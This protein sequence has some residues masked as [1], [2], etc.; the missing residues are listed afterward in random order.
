MRNR[1]FQEGYSL[2]G[3]LSEIDT[4]KSKRVVIGPPIAGLNTR[5]KRTEIEPN[6]SPC[7]KNARIHRDYIEPRPG[8]T[9]ISD[10]FDA[11]IVYI[12]EFPVSTGES[13]LIVITTKSIY[14][15]LNLTTFTR[16]P[17]YY[18]TGTA[19]T[20]GTKI[21]TGSGTLWATNVRPG[22]KFKID[23]VGTWATVETVDSNT[24]LTL[25]TT[26]PAASGAYHIDKYFGGDETQLFWGQ[27]IADVDYFVFSQGIDPVLYIDTNFDEVRRLS[28]DCPAASCGVIFADRLIIGNIPQYPYRIMWCTRGNY[29]DWTGTGSGY[30]DW[31]EDAYEVTGLSVSGDVCLVWKTYSVYQIIQTGKAA[32][33]FE[34]S[35]RVPG[36]GLFY[37]GSLVSIGDADVFAGSDNFYVY[38]LRSPK[39]IGDKIKDEFLH[40]VN[41]EYADC[42]HSLVAEEYNEIQ[43]YYPAAGQT[44][45]QQ[46]LIFNY[47]MEVWSSIW[48][49]SE[50]VTA[51]GYATQKVGTTW[52][53]MTATWDQYTDIWDSSQILAATPLNMVAMGNKLLKEDPAALDDNGTPFTFEWQT[54]DFIVEELKEIS[55]YRVIVD[56]IA[57]SSGII[58]FDVTRDGGYSWEQQRSWALQNYGSSRIQRAYFDYLT[59]AEVLGGRIRASGCRFQIVRIT[60]EAIPAGEVRPS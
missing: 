11:T 16:I 4:P 54:K 48:E 35:M 21:V 2:K 10:S 44:Q 32:D 39:S 6:E 19:T 53:A 24:Q 3:L 8:L 29:T 38:D 55:L 12:R 56:H 30:K 37:T 17:W 26:Y 57:M 51:S 31:I 47:D 40:T 5:N 60:I 27:T 43:F 52:D 34:Y 59:S 18:T 7:C 33:P 22:D 46:A 13:Y 14:Y 58:Y 20:N 45:P 23:S 41:P 49:F 42:A 15:S 36:I 9:L 25:T 28:S 1:N 50:P